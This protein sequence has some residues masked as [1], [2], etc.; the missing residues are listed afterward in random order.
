[1]S[2][3]LDDAAFEEEQERNPRPRKPGR[4]AEQDGE[5]PVVLYLPVRCSSCGAKKPRTIGGYAPKGRRYHV[6][7]RCGL[8]FHSVEITEQ[9]LER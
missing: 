4:D 5:I 1:M 7:K 3:W 2:E 9:D 6:C 8:E